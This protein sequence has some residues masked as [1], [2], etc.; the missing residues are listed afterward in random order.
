MRSGNSKTPQAQIGDHLHTAA[1]ATLSLIPIFGG[2]AA[3]IFAALITPSLQRRRD[4]WIEEIGTGLQSL[5]DQFEDFKLES[6]QQNE[7]FITTL[8]HASASAIR[9]HNQEKLEALRNA[10]LNA[11]LPNSPDEDLQ[12]MF[13]N[14]IDELTGWHLRLLKFLENPVEWAAKNNIEYP[15]WYAGGLGDVIEVAFPELQGRADFYDQ[16]LSD[17]HSRRLSIARG[18]SGL[19]SATGMLSPR[20]T[21]T[22]KQFLSFIAN[23]ETKID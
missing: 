9:N 18:S 7:K 6:L 15:N 8:L 3:E 17:L 22:G 10:V 14:Y 2:P 13:I 5:Q 16:L 12:L 4:N 11:A 21:G 23:P 20:T 1:K 19:I